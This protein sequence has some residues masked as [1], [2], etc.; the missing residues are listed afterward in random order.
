[1]APDCRFYEIDAVMSPSKKSQKSNLSRRSRGFFKIF[2]ENEQI[3]TNTTTAD[4]S[5]AALAS[6][7]VV[8]A[9]AVILR[10]Q[11]ALS[12]ATVYTKSAESEYEIDT[13]LLGE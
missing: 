6:P 9:E 12:G 4:P 5:V 2:N 1:M 13:P 10:E 11:I 3:T 8:A 7:N